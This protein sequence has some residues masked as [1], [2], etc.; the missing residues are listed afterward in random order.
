MKT[1]VFITLLCI[2]VTSVSVAQTQIKTQSGKTYIG[3]VLSDSG[4][5]VVMRTTEGNKVTLLK[6]YISGREENV[7]PSTISTQLAFPLGGLTL[8]TPGAFHILGGYYFGPVGT[9]ASI[10]YLASM[11]G[12]QVNVYRNLSRSDRFSHNL[13]IAAGYSHIPHID[14]DPV[15]GFPTV[16]GDY[17]WTY[18]GAM[19]DVNI[20]GIFGEIGLSFGSGSFHNPQ[21]MLQVGYVYEFRD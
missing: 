3:K 10:G 2:V 17:H 12:I 19:Y 5:Q 18:I 9:R 11:Y 7:D 4:D 6:S 16:V 8:G 20:N 15:F 13:G 14:A 21:L 1:A